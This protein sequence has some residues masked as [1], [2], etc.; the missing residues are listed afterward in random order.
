MN[1]IAAKKPDK[2][3]DWIELKEYLAE[4]HIDHCM[5]DVIS[6]LPTAAERRKAERI[7]QQAQ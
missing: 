4:A 6:C 7:L 1:S 5:F 2:E 3:I